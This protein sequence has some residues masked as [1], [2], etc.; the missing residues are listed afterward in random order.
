[1]RTSILSLA[2]ILAAAANAVVVPK[3]SIAKRA[4]GFLEKCTIL[5]LL[6]TSLNAQCDDEFGQLVFDSINLNNCIGFANND[7]VAV[8]PPSF[9][10]SQ[11]L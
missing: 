11:R 4:S 7:L 8:G 6:G 3:A 9:T 2:F 10:P 5:A 1:M